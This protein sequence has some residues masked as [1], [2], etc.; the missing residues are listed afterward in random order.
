MLRKLPRAV[1]NARRV[2]EQVKFG[3]VLRREDNK[4]EV[5]KIAKH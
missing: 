4:T 1:Y 5:F 3:E 2:A